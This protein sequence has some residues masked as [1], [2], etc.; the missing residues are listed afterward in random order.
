VFDQLKL[1]MAQLEGRDEAPSVLAKMEYA[2][3]LYMNFK[4]TDELS[5]LHLSTTCQW[6][7]LRTASTDDRRLRMRVVYGLLPG[8]STLAV[9]TKQ[10]VFRRQLIEC[11]EERRR[12]PFYSATDRLE[13]TLILLETMRQLAYRT[14][15]VT[16]SHRAA[17][18]GAPLAKAVPREHPHRAYVC[19]TVG[20]ILMDIASTEGLNRGMY[21]SDNPAIPLYTEA[22]EASV[23]GDPRMVRPAMVV[24]TGLLREAVESGD[25]A[26]LH[27]GMNVLKS[28]YTGWRLGPLNRAVVALLDTTATIAATAIGPLQRIEAVS[29]VGDALASV[30]SPVPPSWIPAIVQ[31]SQSLVKLMVSSAL[32]KGPAA[33]LLQTKALVFEAGTSDRMYVPTAGAHFALVSG[34]SSPASVLEMLSE[35]HDVFWQAAESRRE[36]AAHPGG[37]PSFADLDADTIESSMLPDHD[38]QFCDGVPPQSFPSAGENAEQASTPSR[39]WNELRHAAAHG[40]VIVLLS[41]NGRCDAILIPDPV[42]PPRHLHLEQAAGQDLHA[43]SHIWTN[44]T[45]G[46]RGWNYFRG[47]AIARRERTKSSHVLQ[48]LWLKVVKPI[49]LALGLQVR[50]AYLFLLS[51]LTQSAAIDGHLATPN[52]LVPDRRVRPPPSARCRAAAGRVLLGLR[53]LI[54]HVEPGGT[55]TSTERSRGRVDRASVCP[56]RRG[57]GRTGHAA[58]AHHSPRAGCSERGA[59][60]GEHRRRAS[61]GRRRH[62]GGRRP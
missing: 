5:T 62:R 25:T 18:I 55:P 61:G 50:V 47:L 41:M 33:L 15:D 35:V 49:L 17:S 14:G 32:W 52:P 40:P 38:E 48:Q 28:T 60:P 8:L 36:R 58:A 21:R 2:D 34:C 26:K 31:T 44:S 43:W 10:T 29:T 30:P 37:A 22:L 56:A 57:G 11:V 7:V 23:P 3:M 51:V 20:N 9:R 42:A 27:K 19:V 45:S 39:S 1:V 54:I 53:R 24:S 6:Q 4:H 13:G 12:I 46:G 59:R 16:L